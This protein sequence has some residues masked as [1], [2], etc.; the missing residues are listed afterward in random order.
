MDN[1][2]REQIALTRFKTDQSRVGRAWKGT[3]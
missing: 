3:K 2:T 1:E